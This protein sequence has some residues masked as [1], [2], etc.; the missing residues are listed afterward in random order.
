MA[1]DWMKIRRVFLLRVSRIILTEAQYDAFSFNVPRRDENSIFVTVSIGRGNIL[2]H[3]FWDRQEIC[4]HQN[5][6]EFAKDQLIRYRLQDTILN[7]NQRRRNN[8]NRYS[9]PKTPETNTAQ[10]QGGKESGPTD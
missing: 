7:M 3:A 1:D 8:D 2:N 5:N 4:H 10:T 6:N 9:T